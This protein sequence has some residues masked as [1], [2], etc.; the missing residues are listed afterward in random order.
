VPAEPVKAVEPEPEA[1]NNAKPVN[2]VPAAEIP[3]LDML[4]S[5]V[6]NA[7]RLAQK[8]EGPKEILTLL[9][10]F[11]S[12]TGLAFV[13]EAEDKHRPELFNLVLAANLAPPV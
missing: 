6:T 5:V 10:D 7:V 1:V 2:L 11:K 12:K 4:K 9:P 3:P 8:G 13:M